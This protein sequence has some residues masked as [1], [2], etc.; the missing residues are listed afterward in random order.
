MIAE[1]PEPLSGEKS[2][3]VVSR[4]GN[5]AICNMRVS[6]R[7]R[8]LRQLGDIRCDPSRLIARVAGPIYRPICVSLRPLLPLLLA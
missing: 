3:F 2:P 6:H 1:L 5:L 4:A 8:A 7:R